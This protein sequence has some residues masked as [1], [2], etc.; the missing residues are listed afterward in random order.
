MSG[1]WW[2]ALLWGYALSLVGGGVA[3]PLFHEWN[4]CRIDGGRTVDCFGECLKFWQQ[5]GPKTRAR[6]S[7]H[8]TGFIE[9]LIFTSLMIAQPNAAAVAMGGWLALKMAASWNKDVPLEYP[10]DPAR[11]LADKHLWNSH[12]FLGLLSGLASMA[13]AGAGGML[14]R[15]L[16]GFDV[17]N[18]D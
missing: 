15:Y 1:S 2:Q 16:A 7:P 14:T 5:S 8:L 11:T 4:R 10:D 17:I 3:V 6:V 13:M 12:A 18:I 9:R